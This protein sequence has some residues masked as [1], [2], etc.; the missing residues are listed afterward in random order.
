MLHGTM[1]ESGECC[2]G[3]QTVVLGPV[4]RGA[5]LGK[6]GVRDMQA[7]NSHTTIAGC[8]KT[9]NCSSTEIA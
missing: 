2:Y 9:R 3:A 4:P 5:L 6:L 1:R 7:G 8:R